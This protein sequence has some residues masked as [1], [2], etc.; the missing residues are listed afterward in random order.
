MPMKRLITSYPMLFGGLIGLLIICSI[1]V[2][3]TW[4]PSIDAALEGH[5]TFLRDIWC[6]QALFVVSLVRFWPLRRRAAF[7]VSMT[8]FFFLHSLGIFL[9]SLYVH[10]IL[11]SQWTILT[12]VELLMIFFFVPWSTRRFNHYA[13]HRRTNSDRAI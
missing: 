13:R 8:T 10:P 4:F 6:T 5:G 2:I 7:W 1:I 9:Y 12:V 11:M 3:V